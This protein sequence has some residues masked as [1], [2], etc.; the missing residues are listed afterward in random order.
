MT[1]N[2]SIRTAL[3]KQLDASSPV[4]YSTDNTNWINI[5]SWPFTIGN[6]LPDNTKLKIKFNSD[7][8]LPNSF[9]NYFL[10][11][12]N[13]IIIDGNS[14]KITVDNC[15]D[16]PGLITNGTDIENGYSNITVKNISIASTGTTN[17]LPGNGWVCSQYFGKG[18]TGNS[19]Q[20]CSSNGSIPANSGGITGQY[21]AINSTNFT[22]TGCSASGSILDRLDGANA[23]GIVGPLS[24]S[25]STSFTI[26]TSTYSGD[27]NGNGSGGIIGAKSTN[28]SI[29]NC[30]SSGIIKGGG[31]AG[32]YTGVITNL[33][34]VLVTISDC[35][36]KGVIG[37]SK[38][39]SATSA[40]GI[41]GTYAGS[42]T[43]TRC[44]SIGAIGADGKNTCG[45]IVGDYAGL[46]LRLDNNTYSDYSGAVTIQSCFSTGN[47]YD[48]SGGIAGKYFG[49]NVSREC[50]I[51]DSYSLGS[52][53]SSAGGIAG[54]EFAAGATVRCSIL[55]C[56]SLGEFLFDSSGGIIGETTVTYPTN[57]ITVKI[58]DSFNRFSNTTVFNSIVGLGTSNSGT[59]Q[60]RSTIPMMQNGTVVID[61]NTYLTVSSSAYNKLQSSTN[62]SSVVRNKNGY[63]V[64]TTDIM[65]NI[66]FSKID[67]LAFSVSELLMNAGF[68]IN[69]LQS[70]Q[71]NLTSTVGEFNK[72]G[73]GIIDLFGSNYD[74]PTLLKIR[75]NI[76]NILTIKP[77]VTFKELIDIGF[78]LKTNTPSYTIPQLIDPSVFP[79]LTSLD[80]S[81]AGFSI[82]D[83]KGKQPAPMFLLNNMKNQGV[84]AA[85]LLGPGGY[86]SQQLRGNGF[87][88][89]D[90]R[91]AGYS[92]IKIYSDFGFQLEEFLGSK[93]TV[94]NYMP[95][96]KTYSIPLEKLQILGF[97]KVDINRASVLAKLYT[98][99]VFNPDIPLIQSYILNNI[100]VSQIPKTTEIKNM[101]LYWD[102]S[103]IAS[104]PPGNNTYN[105]IVFLKNGWT[106]RQVAGMGFSAQILLDNVNF[107][108]GD[109]KTAGYTYV[110]FRFSGQ[111]DS[112][113]INNMN[114]T[115]YYTSQPPPI[116]TEVITDEDDLYLFLDLA[117][118]NT[119]PD[120]ESIGYSY[121]EDAETMTFIKFTNPLY[122]PDVDYSID[123]YLYIATYNGDISAFNSIS[124]AKFKKPKAVV[125]KPNGLRI[126]LGA[127][128]LIVG[129]AL[130]FSS[131]Q[132]PL[133]GAF[134]APFT[135]M[136]VT[137]G[138]KSI[139][140]GANLQVDGLGYIG[141]IF[142]ATSI[143][144]TYAQEAF[145]GPLGINMDTV[146]FA[147]T[148]G[149][150]VDVYGVAINTKNTRFGV[151]SRNYYIEGRWA[152]NP[153]K[154]GK[155]ETIVIEEINDV[156]NKIT[157][158]Y[159]QGKS[160]YNRIVTGKKIG[161]KKAIIKNE[162]FLTSEP[163]ITS[164]FSG[165][166]FIT[167]YYTGSLINNETIDDIYYS[168]DNGGSWKPTGQTSSPLTISG[169]FNVF[170]DISLCI[171]FYK[172]TVVTNEN[173]GYNVFGMNDFYSKSTN[174]GK[175]SYPIKIGKFGAK[176]NVIQSSM[177]FTPIA[178]ELYYVY[179]FYKYDFLD[180]YKLPLTRVFFIQNINCSGEIIE[181]EWSRDGG[182][183]WRSANINY[184]NLLPPQ[185]M[186][187]DI[188][189]GNKIHSLDFSSTNKI[190][191]P[192]FLTKILYF[193]INI[194]LNELS[195]TYSIM[196]R[197]VNVN[198]VKSL[199]SLV[200]NSSSGSFSTWLG[201][202]YDTRQEQSILF[203]CNKLKWYGETPKKIYNYNVQTIV[204]GV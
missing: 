152:F 157:E 195:P 115:K 125:V 189:T 52:I 192:N 190:Y 13:N 107:D 163:T 130:K 30:S 67:L 173:S 177:V 46:S 142:E 8:T 134:T 182:K 144:S 97:S 196:I 20:N 137:Q 148:P 77:N 149:S 53:D 140:V 133:L 43:I 95:L 54:V 167:I 84:S 151:S 106:K 138:I 39:T 136:L 29:S 104:N 128:M 100:P 165:A 92:V 114:N 3:I 79:V 168:L 80:I 50:G 124:V 188:D 109:L 42:V 118:G 51:Y 44:Y 180:P 48:Y 127:A 102:N 25:F 169:N 72:A 122:I 194:G 55:R 126:G 81:K 186:L 6:I 113:L 69:D 170:D 10:L 12:S 183:N 62:K 38:Y 101:K 58:A 22:I 60:G 74:L 61:G 111:P 4:Q 139:I 193:D 26:T 17:L 93:F 143:L 59:A 200:V 27:I 147:S 129:L 65:K 5:T 202:D 18:S 91:N 119:G 57:K 89:E 71:I 172:K 28:F 121:D 2:P 161:P 85:F 70:N 9:T 150:N 14:K 110:D 35:F 103:Q 176:S 37:N 36:T 123:K 11:K 159:A 166:S 185:I 175:C 7:I 78:N 16:F 204:I 146:A 23:G 21:T 174:S 132:I 90:F 199:P 45:G 187:W 116:I 153:Y 56:Y 201:K 34:Q 87:N 88:V 73:I 33:N 131:T 158:L 15:T 117:E 108:L 41:I 141:P 191:S 66:N 32:D 160:I 145:L 96:C 164:V 24:G 184:L 178:P 63:Y 154:I 47:I 156:K 120:V 203:N 179:S 112:V 1:S 198:G 64:I 68:S 171:K 49:N 83:I 162:V 98:S 135:T 75:Y 19:I 181:Y 99:P 105:P 94:D 155:L 31:I 82:S 86:T 197:C 76:S 40:G